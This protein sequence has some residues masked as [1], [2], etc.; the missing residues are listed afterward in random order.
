MKAIAAP[1]PLVEHNARVAALPKGAPADMEGVAFP[2][3]MQGWV[4]SLPDD[5][6]QV[7]SII[8]ESGGGV[9]IVGGSVRQG[10][11]GVESQEYDL[12][13]N[14]KPEQIIEQFGV[15]NSIDVGA[16]YG[17]VAV[18]VRPGGEFYEITTLRCDQ[19][20]LDGRRPDSVIF[21]N[22]LLEDLERRDLTINAMAVDLSR[23]L[24]Y[25]PFDGYQDLQNGV[26]SA[27]GSAPTRLSEDGLRVMR[28]Y[29]F[30]DQGDA[31]F[32]SPDDDLASG[33]RDCQYMLKNVS[34]ERIW[35]E[36]RRILAGV[37]ASLVLEKMSDDGVLATIFSG[38]EYDL[39]GQAKLGE[40]SGDEM[41][42]ARLAMMFRVG[43]ASALMKRLTMSKVIMTG[44]NGLSR[45]LS[46]L[47]DANSASELR[48]YRAVMG[49]R[50]NQQL[51]CESALA[52]NGIDEVITSLTSLP[53][54]VAGNSPLADGNWIAE[55]TGLS[56]GI[57][58]GR[59]KEWLH[60]I[61]IEEDLPTLA[62]VEVRLGQVAWQ[63]GEPKEWP[64]I[65]WP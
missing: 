39:K 28:A 57:K 54:N 15:S 17:T 34:V 10:L 23:Q 64:R 5:L 52:T 37:H 46:H 31:G 8:S 11:S 20:Y 12:T 25:D 48:L 42:V 22:S 58:L 1:R 56:M 2:S 16:K 3:S 45:S 65:R 35:Q 33:L 7:V 21:G 29:R 19:E 44:V 63:D 27:V 47:P 55:V 38:H 18:R 14:L 30:M 60:R 13:T 40:I 26:L 4:E 50:L 51:A 49:A 41:V 62:E 32:W 43:D 61:Q 6:L 9:W 59:L 36:L 24:L 53:A